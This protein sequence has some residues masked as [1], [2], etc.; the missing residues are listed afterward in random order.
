[1]LKC[2]IQNC[3]QQPDNRT[4]TV[5]PAFSDITASCYIS[6]MLRPPVFKIKIFCHTTIFRLALVTHRLCRD[7]A[8]TLALIEVSSPAGDDARL[9]THATLVKNLSAERQ[10][11]TLAGTM[12]S[13]LR[14]RLTAVR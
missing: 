3:H 10:A 14:S 8:L 13:G 2:L 12:H 4:S 1:M 7:D 6:I 11:P 5:I 9:K